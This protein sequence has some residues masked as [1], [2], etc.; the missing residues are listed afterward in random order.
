MKGI[1]LAAALSG[2][3]MITP[4]LTKLLIDEVYPTEN[5][6]LMHVLVGGILALTITTT[7]LGLVQ[8]YFSL[9]VNT[10]LSSATSLL[11]FNHLQ[12]LRSRFFQQ[13]QVGEITSRFQDV[14]QALASINT[15][16]QTV[17]IHG[18]Y[19]LLVPPVLILLE[20]RLALLALVTLPASFL[21]TVLS[22]P[23][24]RRAWKKSSEAQADLNALQVETL[25]HIQTFKAMGLEHLVYSR[26][27]DQVNQ[28]MEHRLRAGWLGQ[29]FGTTNGILRAANM[30]LFTWMGWSLILS[31]R[32]T[33][34]D[35]MAFSAYVSYLYSPIAQLISLFSSFQQSAVHLNRMFEYL[36]SPVE[37]DPAL[38]YREPQPIATRIRGALQLADVSFGY[39]AE[40]PVLN[41]LDLEIPGGSVTALVGHSGS[42]KTSLLRLLAGLERPDVGVIRFDG[43]PLSQITLGD[44]RRQI[45]VVWQEVGLVKGSLWD[46]LTLGAPDAAPSRIEEVIELCGLQDLLADLPQGLATEVAEWG[47]SLSAGQR[48]RVALARAW[49]RDAQI[50]LLDEATANID[51]ETELEILRRLFARRGDRT[52]L[53]VTHRPQSAAQAERICVLEAGRLVGVGRHRELLESCPQYQRMSTIAT[54]GSETRFPQ[55][56]RA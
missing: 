16:F 22:G 1:F 38:A 13:H 21:I 19:L 24:L 6:S 3:G 15:V 51:V 41:G 42:G 14:N 39:D 32:M 45:A 46:N 10:R 35:F 17:F 4:L 47:S 5:V 40:R 48:Q 55:A 30:G 33:L 27:R 23:V 37:Q 56:Q 29:A 34:G 26:A 31:Q 44:L 43:V 52:I 25:S 54:G 9:Y 50:V 7:F 2:V 53:F 36:D 11:F 12:H 18:I 8:G 28:V 20:W 49:V